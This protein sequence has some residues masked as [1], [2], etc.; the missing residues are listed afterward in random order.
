MQQGLPL[1]RTPVDRLPDPGRALDWTMSG[2]GWLLVHLPFLLKYFGYIA[3]AIALTRGITRHVTL[4]PG[5]PSNPMLQQPCGAFP[6]LFAGG[7]RL[8]LIGVAGMIGFLLPQT[9]ADTVWSHW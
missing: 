1:P 8:L 3:L 2:L 5:D 4:R 9:L 7:F 6:W